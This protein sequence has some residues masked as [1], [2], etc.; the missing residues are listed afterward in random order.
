M[1][2]VA[3]VT[4][5]GGDRGDSQFQGD[6]RGARRP[7]WPVLATGTAFGTGTLVDAEDLHRGLAV[8]IQQSDPYFG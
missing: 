4:V 6:L 3:M 1:V 7:A 8:V 5:S 2:T